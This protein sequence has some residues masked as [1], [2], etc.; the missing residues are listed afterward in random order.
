MARCLHYCKECYRLNEEVNW[1]V[2]K[3]PIKGKQDKIY[4]EYWGWEIDGGQ[5]SWLHTIFPVE[6]QRKRWFSQQNA[7]TLLG[8]CQKNAGLWSWPQEASRFYVEW[9]GR[10]NTAGVQDWKPSNPCKRGE[11]EL[12]TKIGLLTGHNLLPLI[13]R[14]LHRSKRISYSI[15]CASHLKPI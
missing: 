12:E 3:G 5:V 1:R 2:K 6:F 9:W 15:L 11:N 8:K 10:H 4:G 7:T 14:S 13:I